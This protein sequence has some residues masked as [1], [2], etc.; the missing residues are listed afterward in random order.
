MK[1]KYVYKTKKEIIAQCTI[2]SPRALELKNF[3]T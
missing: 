2:L 1:K 3:I